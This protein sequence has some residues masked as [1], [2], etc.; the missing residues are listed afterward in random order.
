[1]IFI[2]YNG[3]AI[4]GVHYWDEAEIN[5]MSQQAIRAKFN[6]IVHAMV[7]VCYNSLSMHGILTINSR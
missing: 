4:S 1:M 7:I 2:G 5:I 3:C 6:F